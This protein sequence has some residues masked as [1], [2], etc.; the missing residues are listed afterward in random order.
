MFIKSFCIPFKLFFRINNLSGHCRLGRT[1]N[2]QDF[3]VPGVGNFDYNAQDSLY[4]NESLLRLYNRNS[5]P[6][7]ILAGN[8]NLPDIEW[9]DG[10]GYPLTMSEINSLFLD[11]VNEYGLE[12]CIQEPTRQDH[13]LDLVFA[14][15][16][17][18]IESITTTPGMSDHEAVI[19]SI[20]THS[21][22]I[23]KKETCKVFVFHKARLHNLKDDFKSF[24]EGFLS[25]DPYSQSVEDN[26]NQFKE[27]II[28]T[29]LKNIPQRKIKSHNCYLSCLSYDIKSKMKERKML[30][31]KAKKSQLPED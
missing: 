21:V 9:Q 16:P 8:F 29:M 30:Y 4:L 20:N 11:M 5:S 27:A 1:I 24:Q 2:S 25:S 26:W 19:F 17:S 10:H 12:Q 28:N 3:F 14:S 15:Q 6:N 23:N 22:L 31:D 18:L 7:L 13:I